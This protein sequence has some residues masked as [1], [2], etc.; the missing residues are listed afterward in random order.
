MDVTQVCEPRPSYTSCLL[1]GVS[2]CVCV[3]ECEWVCVYVECGFL[4]EA[5]EFRSLLAGLSATAVLSEASGVKE[6]AGSRP[7]RVTRRLQ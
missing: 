7:R 2:E 4:S 1:K 6:K 3:C 5:W